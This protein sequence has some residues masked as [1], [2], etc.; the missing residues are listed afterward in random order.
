MLALLV[1]VDIDENEYENIS[2]KLI[3]V[4]YTLTATDTTKKVLSRGAMFAVSKKLVRELELL[5]KYNKKKKLKKQKQKE[6]TC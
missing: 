4:L 2:R 5:Y 6:Q 3:Y 1:D